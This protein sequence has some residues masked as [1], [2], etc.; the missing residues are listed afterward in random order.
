MTKK[1]INLA[2]VFVLALATLL[3]C[4]MPVVAYAVTTDKLVVYNWAE[5]IYD[6]EDE[7][8]QYYFDKTGRNI[9]VTYTTFDTN[10]TMLNTVL[11]GDSTADVICPSE[12]AIEKLINADVLME[13]DYFG[14]NTEYSENSQNVNTELLGAISNAF[15]GY[16]VNGEDVDI[17]KYL[18]PYMWGTIG[19]L[20][21]V[22][23]IEE[24]GL[25]VEQMEESGWGALFNK[26]SEGEKLSPALDKKIYMKD[27]V[28]DSYVAT[29]CYLYDFGMLGG[30]YQ[31]I[32]N[33]TTLINS[34]DDNLLLEAKDALTE[35]KGILYGYEVD[36]GKDDL[37][38]GNAYVDLAWSGDAMYAI[39]EGEMQGVTLDYYVPK[40]SNVWL[41]GW[42]IPKSS[43]NVEQ[44][45]IF[46]DFLNS[47]YVAAQN[48]MEIGYTPAIKK[49][50]ILADSDAMAVLT[51]VYNVNAPEYWTA[52]D[53]NEFDFD[54]VDEFIE[55]FFTDVRYPDASSTSLGVMRDFGKNT[56]SVSQMWESVKAIGLSPWVL[57]G[58]T[59]LV[60]GV[61]GGI[62]A[63]AWYINY[64]KK[65][66]V[67]VK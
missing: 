67:I 6:Y 41:D 28:R 36:F 37:I 48:M 43:P 30:K 35:Q 56:D 62:I 33:A 17:M 23:F 26:N 24:A 32:D 52:E 45:R 27:S 60:V 8:K 9:E 21:N 19:V 44:A 47:P 34:I 16:Q 66:Y 18:V 12:Y 63:L 15:A 49:E 42:V 65:L 39:E 11:R 55:Y 7:F 50:A 25:T 20:Y 54:S 40:T 4:T 61:I 22:D 2:L 51:E 53:G 5:Y 58:Y 57:L 13:I 1:F 64:R 29:L 31:E 14:E 46:I 59:L 10:E 38:K 3:S